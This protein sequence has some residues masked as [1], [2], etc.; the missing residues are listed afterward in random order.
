MACQASQPRTSTARPSSSSAARHR[1]F[2]GGSGSLQELRPPADPR[3]G[4]QVR[5]HRDRRRGDR[6][7]GRAAVRLATTALRAGRSFLALA[8]DAVFGQAAVGAAS[9]AQVASS[10][11][12]AR[13]R[14]RGDPRSVSRVRSTALGEADLVGRRPPRSISGVVRCLRGQARAAP[15]RVV[16]PGVPR[17]PGHR[18]LARPRAVRLPSA[19]ASVTRECCARPVGRMS[20][21]A[22]ARLTTGE[23]ERT[24]PAYRIG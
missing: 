7:A 24:N 8:L 16:Q 20:P 2:A 19:R 21:V 3:P 13:T 23:R 6:P 14:R 12:T 10:E 9:A 5:G 17:R 18:M 15:A 1:S 4:H 22:R 11:P